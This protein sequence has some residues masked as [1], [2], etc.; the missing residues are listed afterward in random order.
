LLVS[1]WYYA[2]YRWL[3]NWTLQR[4]KK[5]NRLIF[6]KGLSSKYKLMKQRKQRSFHTPRWIYLTRYDVSD[7]KPYLEVD[8]LT[9]SAIVIYNPFILE[10]NSPVE[11]P[12]YRPN[13]Y[14]LYNWK[15]I[16]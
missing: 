1:K 9:L 3:T 2:T 16:T 7:I 6:R 14:R 13:I 4:V 10:Y 15:Y 12:D 8:Y 5:Y 11:T